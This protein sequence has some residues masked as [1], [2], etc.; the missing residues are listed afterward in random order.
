MWLVTTL[1]AAII[2]TMLWYMLPKNY[3]LEIPSIMFWGATLM[4]LTDHILG[5]SGGSFLETETEG[6]VNNSFLLGG[7]MVIPILL[8][9][10]GMVLVAK[11]RPVTKTR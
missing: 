1:I 8:C 5:Y 10:C 7:L 6:L 11:Y 2:T 3:R 4:I 9:W